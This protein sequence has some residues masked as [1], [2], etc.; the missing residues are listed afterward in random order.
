MSYV[1]FP[2]C[3]LQAVLVQNRGSDFEHFGLKQLGLVLPLRLNIGSDLY[4][5]AKDL[6]HYLV[7]VFLKS[8]GSLVK[9]TAK[10]FKLFVLYFESSNLILVLLALSKADYDQV[11]N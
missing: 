4:R 3:G 6:V 2:A 7:D 11:T 10:I 1:P 5:T 8:L 9:C